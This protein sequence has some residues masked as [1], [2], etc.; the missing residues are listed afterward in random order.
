MGGSPTI[1][2]WYISGLTKH[3]GD[4]FNWDNWDNWDNQAFFAVDQ[5]IGSGLKHWGP[6]RRE[7]MSAAQGITVSRH[8]A[9]STQVGGHV[10]CFTT[11]NATA[12]GPRCSNCPPNVD[13]G[14]FEICC[15]NLGGTQDF[16]VLGDIID[17]RFSGSGWHHP[18]VYW[19][20]SQPLMRVSKVGQAALVQQT[21]QRQVGRL[22]YESLAVSTS[23]KWNGNEMAIA[24]NAWPQKKWMISVFL[25]DRRP[26]HSLVPQMPFLWEPHHANTSVTSTVPKAYSTGWGLLNG[27]CCRRGLANSAHHGRTNNLEISTGVTG[28]ALAFMLT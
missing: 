6:H 7:A 22:V 10:T 12:G 21:R 11:G 16:Q 24:K 13:V 15:S 3:H 2:W 28:L 20:T 5:L 26:I 1:P 18:G 19:W 27:R 9:A 23:I 17:P 14:R 8:I 25:N 4:I